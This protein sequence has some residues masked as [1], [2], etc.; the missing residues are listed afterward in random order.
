MSDK[1]EKQSKAVEYKKENTAIP[2]D[3]FEARKQV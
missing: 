3:I 2:H 1:R